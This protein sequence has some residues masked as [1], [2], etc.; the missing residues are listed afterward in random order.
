MHMASMH[1]ASTPKASMHMASVHMASTHKASTPK[2]ST[3]KGS[4]QKGSTQKASTHKASTH[5]A[6][7]HW[8]TMSMMFVSS[9]TECCHIL[10]SSFLDDSDGLPTGCSRNCMTR[11]VAN[12][13]QDLQSK[14]VSHPGN[15]TRLF[16]ACVKH[17]LF[18]LWGTVDPDNQTPFF[19]ANRCD[20]SSPNP[21]VS[22]AS[23]Q[24]S[25]R[26]KRTLTRLLR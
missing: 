11:L 20:R 8:S 13:R 14:P 7:T 9:D 18:V 22:T 21:A 19:R 2:G 5:K 25:V 16:P 4:T 24:R 3:Q 15:I 23:S 1:M 26:G 10:F 12:S 6:S 17:F